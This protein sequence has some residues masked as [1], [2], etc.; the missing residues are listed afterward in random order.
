MDKETP[1]VILA[2]GVGSRLGEH[3]TTVPKPLVTVGGVPM[4]YRIMG[5]YSACGF[6]NFIILGGYLFNVMR[7]QLL[8]DSQGMGN[9]AI[10]F[11]SAKSE[12][13]GDLGNRKWRIRLI[14]TGE[15]SETGRRLALAKPHLEGADSFFMTYGDCLSDI[16]FEAQLSSHLASG[17]SATVTAVRSPS[18]YGHV[19]VSESGEIT[20]FVEKPSEDGPLINGGFFVMQREV[21][22]Y[23]NTEENKPLEQ[24][25]LPHL[26]A[27]G[28]LN[29]FTH[30]G[31]WKCMDSPK[32]KA[33]L[34]ALA[35]SSDLP[36]W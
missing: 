23:L 13:I 15:H 30:L 5:I 26:A 16:N 2:G 29:A 10:D 22:Q 6:N 25:L 21:F 27:S 4:I 11:G 18:K 8:I 14:D 31:F 36:G 24:G 32:D 17:K 28:Q 35:D 3:T 34:D 7:S 19:K 20:E 12:P 1:V 9:V 33:E